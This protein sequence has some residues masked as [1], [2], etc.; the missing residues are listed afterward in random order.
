M[1]FGARRVGPLGAG[2]ILLAVYAAAVVA[3]LP[4]GHGVR[5][6]F[7][8]IGPPPA[9]RWVKPP[10]AFAANNVSP[11]PNESEVPLGPQGSDQA[12]V[13]S[14]DS[15]LVLNLPAHAIAPHPPDTSVKVR[16]NPIDP[17]P[18]GPLPQGL[19]PNGNAYQVRLTYQ[20]SG[21]EA[22]AL[23]TPGNILLTVP[24][25]TAGLWFS[26]DGRAWQRIGN[27]TVPGQPVVGGPFSQ[28]G[29]FLA[30]THIAPATKSGGGGSNVTG[31]VI[32]VVLTA[33]LAI[34]LG[35]SPAIR[36]RLRRR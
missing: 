23:A 30:G 35:F 19:R 29:Y 5:P 24:L 8:G 9:Y 1:R 26:V 27:Q 3:S 4:L 20:P 31:I 25:T 15:Q 7:E 22:G 21:Q 12:G 16:V 13:L 6:L 17:A 36:R 10:P 18:L 2:L 33:A 14:E 11:R 34:A 32:A 28:P